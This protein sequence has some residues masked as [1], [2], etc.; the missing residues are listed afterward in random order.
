LSKKKTH[1]LQTLILAL[2]QFWAD[3]GCVIWQP[4]HTEV[5]AGTMNPATFLR[6]LG[7]EPWWVAYVEPSIR[8]ADGRYGENPN[9]WQHFYQFQVILKPDPGDPQERYLQSLVA[10]GVDPSEHDIRFVEDNWVAPALGAWGLGWEVWLDGQEITQYTYFQQAGGQ[11]LDPVS[12]EITYGLERILLVLQGMDNFVDIRWNEQLTY[13]DIYLR[14]EREHSRYNFEIADIERLRTMYEGFEAEAEACLVADLVFPAHDY[15]LKCSHTFNLLNAR[16]AVGVTERAALFGR[17]RDQARR[18]AEAYLAE[19][20]TLGYPWLNRWQISAPEVSKEEDKTPPPEAPASF[21]LEIGIEELPADDLESA[22]RYFEDLFKLTILDEYRIQHGDIKILGTPRRLVISI[23]NLAHKQED[24]Y[25]TVKG[26]AEA[27]A[28]DSDDKPTKALIGWAKKNGIPDELIGPELVEEIEGGRYVTYKKEVKG[29]LTSSRF[30]EVLP[31]FLTRLKFENPMRWNE[32]GMSFSRPIRWLVA[33]HGE[34]VIPFEFAG[35]RTGRVTRGLRFETPEVISIKN[36]QAYLDFMEEQGIIL[37]VTERREEIWRQVQSLAKEVKGKVVE[38]PNL[39]VEVTNL[40]EKPTALRGS[41]DEVYLDLP[42]QVL[43]SVM[44]KH[45]RCFPVERD[46][47]L[48]PYFITV[49]NG[50][51]EHLDVVARGNE[52]VIQ[53]RFADA[54][55]FI[56]SDLQ[57]SLEDFLPR[58]DTMTFQAI[59]GSMLDKVSR[60]ERLTAILADEFSLSSKKKKTALRAA[61]LSKADLATQLV[62]EMTSLQGE[63]GREYAIRSREPKEV[64][65]AILEHYLPR[66][67]GDRLP[68]TMAGLVVGIADRLDTLSGLFAAGLQPTGAKDPFALRRAAIGLVQI[69]MRHGIRL[70]LRKWINQA[71]AGLPIEASNEAME[72]CMDFIVARQQAFLLSEGYSHDAVEAILAEQG[73][74]PSGTLQA[75]EALDKWRAKDNWQSILQAYARCARITRDEA[76][77]DRFQPDLLMED[78]ERTLHSAYEKAVG[79]SRSP[80]SVDDFFST[81]TQMIPA[82][83]RFFDEVLVMTE[84]QKLRDNRLGLL[85]RIVALADSVMDL[86]KLEGF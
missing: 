38:D 31:P 40:V 13:G 64:A 14:A 17:M 5:G 9:R 54:A 52:H 43:A 77:V 63:M 10:L 36:Q 6:V 24:Y 25:T 86:S 3:Q 20:E 29:D 15:V 47:E 42:A 30:S 65:E 75:V 7:P 33:L 44:K 51:A 85:Q 71:S 35:L 41:F 58:L 70:D 78:G 16:G 69:I 79:K 37:D 45:Q 74:D 1:T 18:V 67:A 27:V 26:P 76:I 66:F 19:R 82:I 84:D 57:H 49:R 12:V 61:Q 80:G 34:H 32:T 46:D 23:D 22:M 72:R 28:F 62:V 48:L 81:F 55:Y 60:I 56:Q 50:G 73:H 53:A 11:T 39:L 2:Q 21:L 8:P 4:Y 83:N 68:E 59:L